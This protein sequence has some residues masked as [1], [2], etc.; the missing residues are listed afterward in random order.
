MVKFANLQTPDDNPAVDAACCDCVS[1]QI[2]GQD[3]Q[4]YYLQLNLA[5][6]SE[7]PSYGRTMLIV[8]W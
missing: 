2:T 6:E 5:K 8:F 3:D 7:E 1:T 4:G